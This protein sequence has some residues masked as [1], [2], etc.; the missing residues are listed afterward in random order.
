MKI[1]N[2]DC[3]HCQYS[4]CINDE[5]D[6]AEEKSERKKGTY[7][8]SHSEERKEY[9]KLYKIEHPEE[10]KKCQA[11]YY[12]RNADRKKEYAKNRY[13]EL[14]KNPEWV[15]RE[16]ARAKEKYRRKKYENICIG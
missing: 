4:D 5:F 10:F 13:K 16:R 1:C 15:A 7:Y 12:R 2:M 8:D 9:Q 6:L 14:S 11:E 3:F